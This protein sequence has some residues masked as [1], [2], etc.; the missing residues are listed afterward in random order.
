[1]LK[2]GPTSFD[3]EGARWHASWGKHKILSV[4][5]GILWALEGSCLLISVTFRLINLSPSPTRPLQDQER[6]RR[7]DKIREISMY[8]I[9]LLLNK[10]YRLTSINA[11]S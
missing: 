4:K 8:N 9:S 2:D 7:E 11:K 1:M 10:A 6:R 5:R 3:G